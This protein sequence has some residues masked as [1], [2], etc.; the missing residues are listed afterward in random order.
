M[1]T[2]R[3]W[4]TV[5]GLLLLG[6]LA[7][8]D[9]NKNNEDNNS[10]ARIEIRLTDAPNEHI[11]EV[12]VDIKDIQINLGDSAGWTSVPDIHQGV[13]NLMDLTNGRDTLLADAAIPAGKLNQ[14]RL[15]LGNNNYLITTDGTRE[16]LTTPSAE[17]SGLKV[18]VN[19]DLAG[20]MLYR[21]VLDFDA[22]KSIVTAGNS[23]K[24]LLKPVIRVLSFV[25]SGGIIKGFVAPDSVLT[26]VYAIK[27]TDTISSTSTDAGNYTFRDIASGSYSL[28][29]VPVADSFNSATKNVT[30][31]L[32]QTAIADTVFLEHQ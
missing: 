12:W 21:L 4:Q 17:E 2:I 10:T 5:T 20:G 6:T 9:K 31:E 24:H 19:T 30:V 13:Y 8:C 3:I 15:I 7:A 26:Q 28:S 22:A 32:G 27:G 29:F 1:K 16:E 18:L 23:G 11:R 14:L 25:P